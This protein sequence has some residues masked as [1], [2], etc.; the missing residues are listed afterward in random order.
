M[1]KPDFG[2]SVDAI[3]RQ[4]QQEAKRIMTTRTDLPR[5]ERAALALSI[6]QAAARRANMLR[7]AQND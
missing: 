4:A 7:P 6:I 2:T 1:K 3:L 5:V